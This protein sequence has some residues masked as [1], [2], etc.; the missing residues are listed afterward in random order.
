MKEHECK[1]KVVDFFGMV[2]YQCSC[3]KYFK[4]KQYE[5]IYGRERKERSDSLEE[6]R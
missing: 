6:G 2:T 5:E 3:G 1:P 4:K